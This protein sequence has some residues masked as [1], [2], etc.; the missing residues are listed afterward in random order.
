[1]DKKNRIMAAAESLFKTG[2]LHEITLEEVAR[3]ADVGKGTI[4]QYF[5]SKDDLFFQTAIATFD[6]MC[7]LLGQDVAAEATVEQHLRRACEAICKFAR[8]RRPLFRLIHAEG[9]RTRGKGGGLRQQWNRHR[10]KM[11]QIV[12]GIIR[13]G[14]PRGEVRDDISAEVLAEYFLGMLRT[15]ISELEGLSE[16]DRGG[17]TLVSLFIHGL[18]AGDRVNGHVSP[19]HGG[20]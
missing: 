8:E 1:M 2:Q 7:E 5:D 12:A 11:T 15:R 20:A 19:K 9:E 17:E 10:R 4:Y 18:T 13:S 6:Q 16:E 3:L 14:V